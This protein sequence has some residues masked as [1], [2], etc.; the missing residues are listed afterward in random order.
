MDAE[1]VHD[2]SLPDD[3]VVL[4]PTLAIQLGAG[5]RGQAWLDLAPPVHDESSGGEQTSRV[6]SM[7][8]VQLAAPGDIW[9][10]DQLIRVGAQAPVRFLAADAGKV[11]RTLTE[12]LGTGRGLRHVVECE[13]VLPAEPGDVLIDTEGREVRV[14]GYV[15]PRAAEVR[16]TLTRMI[17]D[18]TLPPTTPLHSLPLSP[19][20]ASAL[21]SI[22]LRTL[23]ELVATS[24]AEL[25]R[26]KR[27]SRRLQKELAHLVAAASRRSSLPC[28]EPTGRRIARSAQRLR[29]PF[30]LQLPRVRRALIA[31]STGPRDPLLGRPRDPA[32]QLTQRQIAALWDM[33]AADLAQEA[34]WR[35]DATHTSLWED[36]AN[37]VPP[38]AA[39]SA[40]SRVRAEL[41]GRFPGAKDPFGWTRPVEYLDALLSVL[42]LGLELESHGFRLVPTV[43]GA[44]RSSPT[45]ASGETPPCTRRGDTTDAW[46]HGAVT[47]A[48]LEEPPAL[49]W[50]QVLGAGE[51][52]L[53]RRFEHIPLEVPL[54]PTHFAQFVAARLGFSPESLV[55]TCHR[56]GAAS[57]AARLGSIEVEG[58]VLLIERLLYRVVPVLPRGLR[59]TPGSTL[60]LSDLYLELFDRNVAL[61]AL[62]ASSAPAHEVEVAVR[63]LQVALD[64]LLGHAPPSTRD[65]GG[66][67]AGVS[68]LLS[69]ALPESRGVD[70]AAETTVVIDPSL[71]PRTVAVGVEILRAVLRPRVAEQLLDLQEARALADANSMVDGND[72]TAFSLL[73][74]LAVG[75]PIWM[76]A[77]GQVRGARACAVDDGA[78]LRV[79]HDTAQALGVRTGGRCVIHW[80]LSEPRVNDEVRLAGAAPA[81]GLGGWM[82]LL[83]GGSVVSPAELVSVAFRG[84]VDEDSLAAR[85]LRL[86]VPPMGGGHGRWVVPEAGS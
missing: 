15:G 57:V 34:V 85:A 22:G 52:E 31:R 78:S 1:V 46:S 3:V 71:S 66:P 67:S 79:S 35:S 43:L 14:L 68:S 82:A 77:A 69:L 54:L 28:L 8:S 30:R 9:R 86:R 81:R 64:A 55:A 4:S 20:A 63:D 72:P 51:E 12:G 47:R 61:R 42:G 26:T 65:V 76:A 38:W 2:P 29:P 17:R 5:G 37:G 53:F 11:T 39:A 62:R 83:E 56:E 25:L 23:G 16:T 6:G 36:F 50:A 45:V 48:A 59:S 24:D 70:F 40:T 80:P 60:V 49:D 73:S 13:W 21:E 33:D 19:E 27:I 7:E 41:E 58:G 32:P 84:E 44:S 10:G 18:A 74:F 75:S